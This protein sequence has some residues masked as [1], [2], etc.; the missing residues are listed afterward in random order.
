MAFAEDFD[1]KHSS[2]KG[3]SSSYRIINRLFFDD[4]T[5][6][7]TETLTLVVNIIMKNSIND[8]FQKKKYY[9]TNRLTSRFSTAIEKLQESI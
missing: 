4:E 1:E 7:Y 5:L 6:M 2:E 3:R 8:I 9:V